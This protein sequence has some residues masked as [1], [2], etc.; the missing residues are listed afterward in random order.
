M[1]IT[2]QS[3][4]PRRPTRDPKG[5][6]RCRFRCRKLIQSI[7]KMASDRSFYRFGKNINP[8]AKLASDRLFFARKREP[9]MAITVQSESPSL[10]T[11]RP[12]GRQIVSPRPPEPSHRATNWP[13]NSISTSTGGSTKTSPPGPQRV[14]A[15]SISMSKINSIHPTSWHPIAYFLAFFYQKMSA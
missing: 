15:M 9:S 7:R 8:S 3:G 13:P 2:I 5:S 1:A 11:D 14:R 10:H 6:A 4:S 12:T